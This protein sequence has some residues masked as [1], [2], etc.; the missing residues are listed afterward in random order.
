MKKLKYL[1]LTCRGIN[2][3][4][5]ECF[6]KECLPNLSDFRF[7]FDIRQRNIHL[8]EYQQ[9]WW[10]NEKKWIVAGH[11][12]SPSIYTI[13]LI[14]SKLILNA[15]TAFRQDVCSTNESIRIDFLFF[16]ELSF[17]KNIE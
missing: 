9:D 15:R 17:I 7:K 12:L 2:A 14:D 1:K 10:K 8:N 16:S 3:S 4:I 11:P 5:W 6:I 13:P